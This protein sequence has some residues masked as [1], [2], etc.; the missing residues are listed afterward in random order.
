MQTAPEFIRVATKLGPNE[1]ATIDA[2]IMAGI[3]A[4]RSEALRWA[5]GRIR[6]NPAWAQLQERVHEISQLKAQF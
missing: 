1:L 3:A 5:V 4:S 6:E 2:L